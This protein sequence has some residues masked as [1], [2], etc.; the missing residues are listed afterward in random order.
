LH[1]QHLAET[2]DFSR[3]HGVEHLEIMAPPD[4]P[5]WVFHRDSLWNAVEKAERRK[6]AQLAREI[7]VALPIELPKDEQ[8]ELLRNFAHRAF[9]SKGM[10]VDMALHRDNLRIRTPT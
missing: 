9:V 5:P 8:V 6:D 4:A 10:L 1:D 2:F 3:K 7:E